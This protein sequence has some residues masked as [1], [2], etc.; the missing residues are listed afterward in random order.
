MRSPRP[1][2]FL[3][4][5]LERTKR[6]GRSTSTETLSYIPVAAFTTTSTAHPL[7]LLH[8]SIIPRHP[9]MR[10]AC[11]SS[12]S[13]SPC[14]FLRLQRVAMTL[15]GPMIRQRWGKAATII[16]RKSLL[17]STPFGES[18]MSS[19]V[20]AIL[21]LILPAIKHYDT[22]ATLISGAIYSGCFL[23]YLLATFYH[24]VFKFL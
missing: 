3:F 17:P 2:A 6:C 12:G 18:S 14:P 7:P 23:G 24:L 10:K 1:V 13:L 21:H 8:A 4:S 5:V 20:L 19:L 16:R 11:R 15:M 9:S 22:Y